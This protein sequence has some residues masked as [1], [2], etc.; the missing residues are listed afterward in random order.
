M[1]TIQLAE[2]VF[3]TRVTVFFECTPQQYKEAVERR[4]RGVSVDLDETEDDDNSDSY[5]LAVTVGQNGY[6]WLRDTTVNEDND[7][8][9]DVVHE[10]VHLIAK[11]LR[12][13]G[14]GEDD[15]AE[16]TRAYLES[17]YVRGLYTRLLQ[18]RRRKSA[19]KT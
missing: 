13:L 17:F 14:M 10:M 15:G 2:P 18:R 6:L 9:L 16:E 1:Q 11:L 8:L 4:E 7:L 19:R 3:R 5:G 12:H